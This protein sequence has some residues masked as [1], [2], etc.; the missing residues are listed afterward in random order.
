MNLTGINY[1]DGKNVPDEYME[2]PVGVWNGQYWCYG[3]PTYKL[4]HDHPFDRSHLVTQVDDEPIGTFTVY[5]DGPDF[6]VYC[7]TMYGSFVLCADHRLGS[8]PGKS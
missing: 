7:R 4:D 1:H 5:K 8:P 2:I 6:Y 3:R